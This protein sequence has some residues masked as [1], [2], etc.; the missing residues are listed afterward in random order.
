[1]EHY[2]K[3]RKYAY[4]S[5]IWNGVKH[6]KPEV[7]SLMELN[8][9]IPSDTNIFDIGSRYVVG[10]SKNKST[11]DTYNINMNLTVS[12]TENNVIAKVNFVNNSGQSF[13]LYKKE[14]PIFN[15]KICEDRFLIITDD[16]QLNY[17]GGWCDFG[18]NFNQLD[19]VEV[20][21]GSEYS[22]A[23][24]LNQ[25]YEFLPELKRYSIGSLEQTL[26]NHD[27]MIRR[28]TTELMFSIL[29][30]HLNC[31]YKEQIDYL[32]SINNANI[33]KRK[34]I[35]DYLSDMG[36]YERASLVSIRTNEFLIDIDGREIKSFYSK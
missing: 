4:G 17:L 19:W 23:I 6:S 32:S 36:F 14:L 2:L 9:Y 21:H 27:W 22:Y 28:H 11:L 33:C 24:F 30:F 29:D 34:N 1:M 10:Q 31:D 5:L 15:G 8:E 3:V 35:S 13:F 12:I 18:S 26:I 7:Y 16:I 20:T 25:F